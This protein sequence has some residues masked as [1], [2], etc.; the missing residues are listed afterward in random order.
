MI[1]G[2]L[3]TLLSFNFDVVHE[4]G[5]THVLTVLNHSEEPKIWAMETTAEMSWMLNPKIFRK[6]TDMLDTFASAA[7]Q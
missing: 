5:I 4:P 7:D 1:N 6:I 3:E 2:W